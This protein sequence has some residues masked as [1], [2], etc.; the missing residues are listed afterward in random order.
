MPT[1]L[2]H[3]HIERD[4]WVWVDTGTAP[5]SSGDAIVALPDWQ[6]LSKTH[7]PSDRRIGVWLEV[8]AEPDSVPNLERLPLIAIRF[9][10]FND[11]RGLSLATLLRTRYGYQGEL[12]AIGAV[13]EDTVHYLVRCGFDSLLLPDDR[14]VE[15]ALRGLAVY[16]DYYQGSVIEA[17]PAFR[18]I[19]RG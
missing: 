4:E 13:H 3:G 12:R 18:R 16:S 9:P 11:G 14:N 8:D 2:K 10:A 1:L 6:T 19:A 5:P 15:V 17:R 7:A